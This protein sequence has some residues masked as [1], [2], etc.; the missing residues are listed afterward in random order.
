MITAGFHQASTDGMPSIQD[1]QSQEG[2]L[3]PRQQNLQAPP[4][5]HLENIPRRAAEDTP[6]RQE[7]SGE[8]S[9]ALGNQA[10]TTLSPPLRAGGFG[11]LVSV[12]WGGISSNL[13]SVVPGDALGPH[14]GREL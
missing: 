8:A 1:N 14:T 5:R 4:P 6:P 9:W 13:P 7:E 11:L 12:L 2:G 10:L 3:R